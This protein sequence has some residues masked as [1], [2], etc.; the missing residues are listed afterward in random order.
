MGNNSEADPASAVLAKLK[1]CREV[2]DD[3]EYWMAAA[4]VND[5]IHHVEQRLSGDASR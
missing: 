4:C 3:L 1:E 5:A 2:L